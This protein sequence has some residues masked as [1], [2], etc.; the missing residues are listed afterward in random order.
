MGEVGE[1]IKK[2]RDG[3]QSGGNFLQEG[4][5]DGTSFWI[6]DLV[7]FGS[8]GEEGASHTKGFSKADHGEAG[9][10]EVRSDVGDSQGRISAG[11]GGNSVIKNL[12][13]ETTG[14]GGTVG[15][16]AADFE[17]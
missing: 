5:T 6:R 13:R 1:A 9:A 15:G 14:D 3:S 10:E 12:Y 8:D 17:V 4:A 2:V 7:K 11:S 16:A